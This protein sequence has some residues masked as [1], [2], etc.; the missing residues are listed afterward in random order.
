MVQSKL[1]TNISYIFPK[2]SAAYYWLVDDKSDQIWVPMLVVTK[3]TEIDDMINETIRYMT[4]PEA[5]VTILVC[6]DGE[7]RLYGVCGSTGPVTLK[8]IDND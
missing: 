4:S 5:W 3:G 6:D 1:F 7:R 2:Y 8:E